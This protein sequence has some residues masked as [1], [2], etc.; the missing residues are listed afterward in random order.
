MSR[1]DAKLETPTNAVSAAQRSLGTAH[2]NNGI[3]AYAA[4]LTVSND[5]P[6]TKTFLSSN[7]TTTGD[8]INI[9]AHG[10]Q[11]GLLGLLTTTSALPTGFANNVNYYAIVVDANNI[12]LALS[13]A[14]ALAGTAVAI[15]AKDGAGTHSFKP[16]ALAN[17][18]HHLAGSI[19]GINFYDIAGSTLAAAGSLWQNATPVAYNYIRDELT[20][21]A[22]QVTRTMQI[23]SM[24]EV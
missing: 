3:Q 8:Y 9:A 12:K 10:Y 4:V 23:R 24:G 2:Q 6:A 22:G 17:L 16:T 19:D 20:L 1:V 11:N 5:S 7:M 13:R 21:T 18:D 15:S 14:A